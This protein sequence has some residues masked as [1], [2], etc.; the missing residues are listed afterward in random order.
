MIARNEVRFRDL[1]LEE[2]ICDDPP[3]H[4]AAV[5]L[6]R[7]VAAGRCELANW[8]EAVEQ[9]IVRVNRLREWMPE[10]ELP[11]IDEKDRAAMREHVFATAH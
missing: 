11:E 7:E 1:V 10:P 4:A 3:G 8:N 6:A 9:W 2:K 5:I